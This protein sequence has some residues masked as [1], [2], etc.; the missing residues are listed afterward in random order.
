METVIKPDQIRSD[1]RARSVWE[2]PPIP[3]RKKDGKGNE[4]RWKKR[5]NLK[6]GGGKGWK[7]GG[8]IN[9]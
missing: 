3:I 6:G 8:E 1:R 2:E 7:I 5:G 4:G 9:R